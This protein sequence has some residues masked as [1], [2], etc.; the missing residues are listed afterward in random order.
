VPYALREFNKAK[1][2]RSDHCLYPYTYN[3]TITHVKVQDTDIAV[4]YY[5][6]IVTRDDVGVFM[7]RRHDTTRQPTL[8]ALTDPR[9]AA[10]LYGNFTAHSSLQ[11]P[12]VAF[13][14]LPLPES[15][16]PLG[17]ILLLS[18]ADAPITVKHGLQLLSAPDAVAGWGWKHDVR[19]WVT[20]KC[21]DQLT[22][23]DLAP[24][25]RTTQTSVPLFAWAAQNLHS[26]LSA[27]KVTEVTATLAENL[28]GPGIR[29]KMLEY[30]RRTF[31]S[32]SP[33]L[34][35]LSSVKAVQPSTCITLANGRIVRRSTA[36]MCAVTPTEDSVLCNVTIS[37]SHKVRTYAGEEQVVCQVVAQDQDIPPVTVT[38]PG[39]VLSSADKMARIISSTF[40]AHGYTPYIAMYTVN[41]YDWRDIMGRLAERCMLQHE[42]PQLGIDDSADLHLPCA[43]CRVTSNEV[44]P[45]HQVFTLPQQVVD[46]YAAIKP[47]TEL[48]PLEPFRRLIAAGDSLYVAAFTVG[49]MH[50]IYQ[51][52]YTL[53]NPAYYVDRPQRNLIYVE[54]EPGI[55]HTVFSQLSGFFSGRDQVPRINYA[56]PRKTISGYQKLGTLPLITEVPSLRGT[57]LAMAI[58]DSG[59]SIIG[60][61]DPQTATLVNGHIP[62]NYVLPPSG[63]S[64]E[65][66]VLSDRDI[67]DLR[68]ALPSF[69][70]YILRTAK[71]TQA[72]RGTTCPA[73]AAYELCC[74][75]L[76][77]EGKKLIR[78]MLRQVYPGV[79]LSGSDTFLQVL[80][81]LITGTGVLA[82]GKDHLTVVNGPP[83]R[84]TDFTGRG[85][86]I[87]VM[88]D[89]VVISHTAV[90][91]A[92][93]AGLPRFEVRRLEQDMGERGIL[94][95][96]TELKDTA[97]RLSISE[98]RCWVMTR[99]AWNAYVLRTPIV[100]PAPVTQ[101]P[102]SLKSI[103]L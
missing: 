15:F 84:A 51:M 46:A 61:C 23:E 3:G 83:P 32:K 42:V 76:D 62:A 60:L 54:S 89:V 98:A 18:T 102:I 59:V 43:I 65:P 87:F 55:W 44:V 79:L 66:A 64:L 30:T 7:E 67:D 57:K 21:S 56:D 25:L 33:L 82:S 40:A 97:T 90:A 93:Q 10:I 5:D 39:A 4:G 45:Q 24:L 17:T 1:Y 68:S 22:A 81:R 53:Y 71:Q 8:L 86:H 49:L 34:D 70:L 13:A 101:V 63:V 31:G 91:V 58:A 72:Y 14:G 75:L 36:G 11:P 12:V 9:A 50:V 80:S 16:A 74:M 69:L 85:H 77:V 47:T 28:P 88:D 2:K 26:D 6:A 78:D 103:E 20:T 48:N 96:G 92:N 52:T 41:G 37:V 27:G 99:A 73:E 35:V 100:L 19:I 29:A 38:F 95:Q 94:L